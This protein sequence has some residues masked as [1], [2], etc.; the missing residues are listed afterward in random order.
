MS[1]SKWAPLL[2]GHCGLEVMGV[3]HSQGYGSR[4]G[5]TQTEWALHTSSLCPCIYTHTHK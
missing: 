2:D 3:N 5:Y 4:E 1:E